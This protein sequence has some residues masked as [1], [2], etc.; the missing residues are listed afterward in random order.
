M[1]KIVQ[2]RLKRAALL[3]FLAIL[4]GAGIAYVQVHSQN[5]SVTHKPVAGITIGGAYELTDQNGGTVTD[6]SFPD[7]YK[8]IYFGFTSCPAICP[9]EM[10]KLTQSLQL[11][12]TKTDK[13]QPIFITVDPERDT[14]ETLKTFLS[15]F[16][17]RFIG[18]TGT[19]D[20]INAVIRDYKIFATKQQD[21]AG[22]DYT[23]DHSSFIYFLGPGG[24]LL[25]IF[26][27]NDEAE[28]IATEI[29]QKI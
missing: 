11:L 22:T 10:K 2:N 1:N 26:R 21:P 14:P 15:L 24:E 16:D 17:P 20:K 6:Q 19:K 4:V 9:T 23:M 12:G 18:L 28:K 13:I 8:L 25:S 27:S 5:A 7:K 29:A 3:S